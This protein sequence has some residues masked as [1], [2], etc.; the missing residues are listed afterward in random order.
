MKKIIVV[1]FCLMLIVGAAMARDYST[2]GTLTANTWATVSFVDGSGNM[3]NPDSILV[4]NDSTTTSLYVTFDG[5]TESGTHEV[6]AYEHVEVD[7]DNIRTPFIKLLST[8]TPAYRIL[9]T[10]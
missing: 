3:V 8:G 7:G 6:K 1:L 4:I 10:W 5:V 2:S 9:A